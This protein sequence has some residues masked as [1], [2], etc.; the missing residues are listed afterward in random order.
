[1]AQWVSVSAPLLPY[2]LLG[3]CPPVLTLVAHSTKV[4]QS[5]SFFISLSL[6]LSLYLS[7]SLR[8]TRVP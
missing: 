3:R 6:S 1:M 4:E 7:L 5:G 2:R 8:M